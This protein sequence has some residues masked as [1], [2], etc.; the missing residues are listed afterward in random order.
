MWSDNK[1]QNEFTLWVYALTKSFGFAS[2]LINLD[3]SLPLPV[4]QAESF[5][6]SNHASILKRCFH[7][8]IIST[9][10]MILNSRWKL[11]L[12]MLDLTDTLWL[13]CCGSNAWNCGRRYRRINQSQKRKRDFHP[14]VWYW[15]RN[16]RNIKQLR[17]GRKIHPSKFRFGLRRRKLEKI[18]SH[19]M[20]G[21]WK[22]RPTAC[23]FP[24]RSLKVK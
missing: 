6:Y 5:I 7:F 17:N 10:K 11:K 16:Y 4:L 2:P 14:E 15:G 12:K 22:I 23:Q 18:T 8:L 19:L 20:K 24:L 21:K 3:S 13:S 1:N 9:F